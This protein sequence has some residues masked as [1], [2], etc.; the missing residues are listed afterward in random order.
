MAVRFF[1]S[2]LRNYSFMHLWASC[3]LQPCFD[4]RER[5]HG[6]AIG[7]IQASER[8]GVKKRPSAI[9]ESASVQGRASG[10]VYSYRTEPKRTETL[11]SKGRLI[12]ELGR[13][14]NDFCS[15][16][17]GEAVSL[18]AIFAQKSANLIKNSNQAEIAVVSYGAGKLKQD[19]DVLDRLSKMNLSS[20]KLIRYV[21]IDPLYGSSRLEYI[22]RCFSDLCQN[23]SKGTEG[24]LVI[25]IVAYKSV[26]EYERS[27]SS[28]RESKADLILD[29][30]TELFEDPKIS[31]AQS[32][33]HV[34]SRNL[35][36]GGELLSL[37]IGGSQFLSK[38][39]NIPW[40]SF[41][42]VIPENSPYRVH[43]IPREFHLRKLEEGREVEIVSI[44]E[45]NPHTKSMEMVSL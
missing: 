27:C 17:N 18:R 40:G 4:V 14:F 15:L 32:D 5:T 6:V 25:D 22:L 1:S 7:T 36:I 29:C 26:Q 3:Y 20:G 44:S 34:L 9:L 24:K 41:F 2:F 35:N 42:H 39:C 30:D 37:N 16:G 38:F 13:C 31:E 19:F 8:Q 12:F 11:K 43:G 10:P 45:V 21:L 33:Y 23:I 28:G